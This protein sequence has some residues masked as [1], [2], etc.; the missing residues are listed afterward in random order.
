MLILID[1]NER[2]VHLVEHSPPVQ[3]H[4]YWCFD[5]LEEGIITL[6]QLLFKFINFF[7]TFVMNLLINDHVESEQFFL[8]KS[9]RLISEIGCK[10]PKD[11]WW[12]VLFFEVMSLQE[13]IQFLAN[14]IFRLRD[15]EIFQLIWLV[16]KRFLF[17]LVLF[18]LSDLPFVVFQIERGQAV[19]YISGELC[20]FQ[21][22]NSQV[23]E[24]ILVLLFFDS[25]YVA[26]FYR[27]YRSN[28]FFLELLFPFPLLS[29]S[30]L[31]I[32]IH[33]SYL[34]Q[35]GPFFIVHVIM[36]YIF[37]KKLAYISPRII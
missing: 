21:P 1:R 4:N 23:F 12:L 37:L 18:I 28:T 2:F 14:D 25:H 5:F 7:L 30:Q 10:Q 11:Q 34:S 29:V 17:F 8:F 35:V 22:L 20:I 15:I 36:Y 19:C 6:A 9:F 32:R 13:L 26:F 31:S 33:I 3:T 24:D 16:Y 27:V